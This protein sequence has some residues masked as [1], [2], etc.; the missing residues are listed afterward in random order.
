[1]SRH[2]WTLARAWMRSTFRQPLQLALYAFF[3]LSLCFA[4]RFELPE[5][6]LRTDTRVS[7]P[8]PDEPPCSEAPALV[9]GGLPDWLGWPTHAADGLH[10]ELSQTADGWTWRLPEAVEPGQ[11]AR[12]RACLV[13]RFRVERARRRAA[14]GHPEPRFVVQTYPAPDTSWAPLPADLGSRASL[15]LLLLLGASS[16]GERMAQLRRSGFLE[17]LAAV[18]AGLRHTVQA[19]FLEQLPVLLLV[20]AAVL[21]WILTGSAT[22]PWTAPFSLVLCQL[23]LTALAFRLTLRVSASQAANLRLTLMVFVLAALGGLSFLLAW[24]G[25]PLLAACLPGGLLAAPTGVLGAMEPIAW[26][27]GGGLTH[28]LYRD[29]L[30]R[31]EQESPTSGDPLQSRRAAGRWGPEALVLVAVASPAPFL[32]SG[33]LVPLGSPSLAIGL[34]FALFMVLP[35]LLAAPLLGLER[36]ALLGLQRPTAAQLGLGAG[37]GLALVPASLALVTLMTSLLPP[38]LFNR[39]LL[40]GLDDLVGP[41][42]V[43]GLVLVPALAE[44]LLFRGA[45]LGLLQRSGRAWRANLLQAGAFGVLHVA[46]ARIPGTFLLGLVAGG[47]RHRTDSVWPAVTMHLVHNG[48]VLLVAAW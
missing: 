25:R 38:S 5:D 32:V 21:I 41:F 43:V 48:V 45:V 2:A 27:L 19:V 11:R 14:A 30:R 23:L 3:G 4:P 24:S 31:L 34:V 36:R 37:L 39:R 40:A 12:V 26:V 44:E 29:G 6:A 42:A 46:L 47:L 35:A 18:P 10:L 33:L 28:L 20:G 15:V 7:R 22:V 1:M 17:T 8:D 13:E 16:V 9:P